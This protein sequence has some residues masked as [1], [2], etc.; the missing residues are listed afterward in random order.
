MKKIREAIH[1][2][3]FE[4]IK[5]LEQEIKSGSIE[6]K[7]TMFERMQELDNVTKFCAVCFNNIRDT[8]YTYSILFGPKDFRRK[9]SF[10]AIDCMEYFTTHL[11]EMKN[12]EVQK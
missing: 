3:S 1:T 11:K 10:C 8:E 12:A 2:L 4:E 7:K 9:A 6:L 5:Q